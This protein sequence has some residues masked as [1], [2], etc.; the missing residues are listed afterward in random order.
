MGK[1]KKRL[2]VDTS[3]QGEK[4]PDD[5]FACL[6]SLFD[7]DL[8]SQEPKTVEKEEVAKDSFSI[9]KSRKGAYHISLKKLAGNRVLTIIHNVVGDASK[10]LKELKKACGAGGKIRENTIELQGDHRKAVVE[11]LEK[12]LAK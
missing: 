9:E 5:R 3:G 7:S 12:R 4:L 11:Y 1:K 8:P 10:L 2:R 6:A